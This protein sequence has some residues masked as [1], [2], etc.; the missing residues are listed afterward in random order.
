MNFTNFG[1]TPEST[2]SACCVAVRERS[3]DHD[4]GRGARAGGTRS[5]ER[6]EKFQHLVGDFLHFGVLHDGEEEV[7]H[8]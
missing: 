3:S 7:E 2:I 6:L 4:E 8:A 1:N 5:K